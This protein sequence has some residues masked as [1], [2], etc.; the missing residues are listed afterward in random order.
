M[1]SGRREYEVNCP[2]CSEWVFTSNIRAGVPL[3]LS[4]KICRNGHPFIVE[5][6]Y[7][8]CRIMTL[9]CEEVE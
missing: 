5:I 8:H 3:R 2:V 1:F 6:G 9:E 7:V 4:D